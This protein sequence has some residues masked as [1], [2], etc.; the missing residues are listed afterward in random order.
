VGNSIQDSRLASTQTSQNPDNADDDQV[1]METI[2]VT[3][4]E[5]LDSIKE[6]SVGDSIEG[7]HDDKD[8]STPKEPHILTDKL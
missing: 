5:G 1:S 7:V 6:V 8:G 4:F 3:A 2:I